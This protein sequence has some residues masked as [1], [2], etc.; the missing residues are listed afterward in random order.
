MGRTAAWGGIVGPAAFVGAWALGGLVTSRDYSPVHDTISQ[1]AAEGAPTR[2]LMTA[3]MVTFGFALP[4]YSTALRRAVPGPA[5]L[6]AAATGVATLGVAA[7]P[8][9]RSALIDGLHVVAAATGYVTLAAIPLLAR[10][11]LIEIGQR[12]LAR[13]GTVM[14]AV[15]AVALPLSLAVSETGLLQRVGLTAGD[16]FVVASVP[17]LLSA[18]HD[19]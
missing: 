11:P 12:G 7:T 3:G 5:W 14:A 4:A 2:G 18:R 8:L 16:L 6:A 19:A 10:R 1:L 15:A 9:D 13:I 17:V